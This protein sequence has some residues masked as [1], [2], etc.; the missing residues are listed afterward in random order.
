MPAFFVN[1]GR[2]TQLAGQI[3]FP[4]ALLLC[5]EALDRCRKS[6]RSIGLAA[7]A[8]AGLFMTHNRMTIFLLIFVGIY[9]L[10]K[11]IR[12]WR[13][14][15]IRNDL[16]PT[17]AL[18]LIVA[19]VIELSW[20]INF[21]KVFGTKLVGMLLVGYQRSEFGGY[22]EWDLEYLIEFGTRW[23][24]WTLAG[25]G[26]LI[27]LRRKEMGGIYLLVGTLSVLVLAQTNL[28]GIPP[29][30]SVLIVTIW[31]Y[32]PVAIL[33][34]YSIAQMLRIIQER[35]PRRETLTIRFSSA[36]V[37]VSILISLPGI[38]NIGNLTLPDNGFVREA[39]LQAM[40]WIE[41]NIPEDALF[42]TSTHFWTP[43]LVHGLD[44]GYWIPYLAN[45]ETILPPEPYLSDGE[46]TYI[47]FVNSRAHDLSQQ[48]DAEALHTL[49]NKYDA[50]HIYIGNRQAY[51]NHTEFE[52]LPSRYEL[53]YDR[54]EVWIFRAIP[55]EG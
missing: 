33:A 26:L 7:I 38:W 40:I 22:Y 55:L 46:L 2:Y 3:L 9:F 54:E 45:R 53:I 41:E 20:I 39:D 44:A 37:V 21:A 50:T 30:F 11:L 43:Y 4:V 35:W 47:N 23:E 18:I 8:V 34:G 32:F 49:L 12:G 52:A 31:L 51:L 10:Y 29:L 16:L 27:S 24:L 19:I 1:W 42:Y 6:L 13:N 15:S 25:L 17:F 48:P 28:I 5:M 14:V 36:A